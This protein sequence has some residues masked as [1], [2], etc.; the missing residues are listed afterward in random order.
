MNR[1]FVSLCAVLLILAAAGAACA[2]PDELYSWDSYTYGLLPDGTAIITAY[3]DNKYE[4]VISGDVPLLITSSRNPEAVAIPETIDGYTVS[5][6]GEN[7]F[8]G[9]NS[10]LELTIPTTVREIGDEAFLGCG[11]LRRVTIPGNVKTIGADAFSFCEQLTEVVLEEGVEA[12]GEYAFEKCECLEVISFPASLTQCGTGVLLNCSSLHTIHVS[13]E[14]ETLAVIDGALY[15]I[16]S[17]TLLC[18][19]PAGKTELTVAKSTRIIAPEALDGCVGLQRVLLPESLEEIGSFAFNACESLQYLEIPSGV[20]RFGEYALNGTATCYLVVK[21]SKAAAYCAEMDHT[22]FFSVEGDES[23]LY[24]EELK[25]GTVRIIS[26]CRPGEQ[27]VIPGSVDGRPPRITANAF[28]NYQMLCC[29]TISEGVY[30]IG[31][32][33]FEGCSNMRELHLPASLTEIDEDMLL[34][35]SPDL[36][37]IVT[38]GS[39]AEQY[40]R[41]HGHR[42]SYAD[43]DS[44]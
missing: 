22:F 7:A 41:E 17:H 5:A 35:C 1:L 12:V 10:I 37:V 26:A 21:G 40:C 2:E 43:G 38:P 14:S 4:I 31:R 27:L 30:A 44:Q 39:L 18:C 15:N 25:D 11:E 6:I 16:R 8:T 32:G 29:V 42:Y 9:A 28:E 34:N 20:E 19:A 23:G 33:A 13:A 36:L 3:D 24:Y